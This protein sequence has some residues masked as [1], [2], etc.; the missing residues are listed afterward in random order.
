M[1]MIKHHSHNKIYS[2]SREILWILVGNLASVSGSLV[3]VRVLTEYLPPVEYGV[4]ALGM[5]MALLVNQVIMGGIIN[6]IG[7]FYSICTE[8]NDLLS[9]FRGSYML[10]VYATIVVAIISLLLMIILYFCGLFQWLVLTVTL[11]VFSILSSYNSA[12][13]TIQNSARQRAIVAFFSALDAWLKIIFVIFFIAWFGATS[14]IV[15]MGYALS[16]FLV[17]ISQFILLRRKLNLSINQTGN[18]RPLV[19]QM[20][21]YA[22]PFS[23]WGIF[24]WL[25]F[26][27]DRW[28]LQFFATTK[29]VGQY[30]VIYQLGFT[31]INLITGMAI[32][33][34]GPILYQRSGDATNYNRNM[35]VH[36]KVWKMVYIS[37]VLSIFSFFITFF[38]HKWIFGLL[39]THEYRESSYLLPW[40]VLAGGMFA[41][42]QFIALK[43]MSEL[44]SD[45]ML[46]AKIVSPLLGVIFNFIG[47]AIAGTMGV[48]VALVIS[49]FIYF[50][51]MAILGNKVALT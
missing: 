48:V 12:L 24:S 25:Q 3:L 35:S 45:K 2:I 6:S 42:G 38:L 22:L 19:N 39:V 7:R 17:T 43:L 13:V 9:Y 34:I 31:P 1:F 46:L 30:A 29:D 4:L 47:A 32:N 15:V 44:K 18:I 33:F 49:F 40:V 11:A 41:S 10:M 50:F 27:S 20:W 21:A 14:S 23:I 8:K 51:W 37:I 36:K 28:A 5:T 16:S 26:S